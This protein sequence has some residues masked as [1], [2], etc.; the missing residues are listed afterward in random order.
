MKTEAEMKTKWCPKAMMMEEANGP[1]N[2]F[3]VK[4]QGEMLTRCIGEECG[5]WFGGTIPGTGC[6]GLSFESVVDVIKN[7]FKLQMLRDSED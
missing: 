3:F 6:C 5:V 4:G 1:Y 2:R 7:M